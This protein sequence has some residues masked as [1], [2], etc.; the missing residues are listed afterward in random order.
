MSLL[1]TIVC[2][3]LVL[4]IVVSIHEFGHFLFAKKAGIYVYEFSIGMGPRL[5]K[6]KR[7]ND[8]TD[9]S[10]RLLP[11]GGYVQMAGE[12]VEE[13][14]NIPKEKNMQTKTWLQKFLVVI[15]GILFN[16]ILATIIFFIVGLVNGVPV[17]KPYVTGI[18]ENTPA[19][20]A[21]FRDGDLITSIN[22]IK[23]TN[24]DRLLIEMQVE[25]GETI[26]FGIKDENNVTK[27]VKVTPEK[28]VNE[29]GTEA[30]KYGFGLKNDVKKGFFESIKYAFT[31][32][33]SLIGQMILTIWYLIIG[34]LSLSN[35]SGPVGIFSIVDASAKAGF[36]NVI[37]L[38]GYLSLNVGFMN[39]LPI[40]ALDGGRL[41]FLII[42]KIIRKPI[43]PKVENIIHNVGFGLLMLLIIVVSYND[44]LRIFN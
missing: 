32:F 23:I 15:A 29:D 44:I 34:K 25:M 35:L 7:K 18:V 27:K 20:N 9:Y 17:N 31:H 2:F 40:P 28:T 5:F 3:A 30:Y 1:I 13:D 21:G 6:F 24:S 8:E 41:L 36:I 19:Y 16:F 11:I 4:S 22:G 37:Y 10:I 42:E 43:D 39:L 14:K 38:T 33:F 12:S 26:E